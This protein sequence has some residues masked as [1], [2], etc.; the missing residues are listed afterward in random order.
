MP[1]LAPSQTFLT[2]EE[3]DSGLRQKG[4]EINKN[5]KILSTLDSGE[6]IIKNSIRVLKSSSPRIFSQIDRVTD[7]VL[8]HISQ[9]SNSFVSE[10]INGTIFLYPKENPTLC[11]FIE[12]LAHQGGHLI[13]LAATNSS[14][15]YFICEQSSYTKN[16]HTA[17]SNSRNNYV[18]LHSLFTLAMIS[19]CLRDVLHSNLI[20]NEE[21]L[22]ALGRLL[23][24]SRR[25]E[26]DTISILQSNALNRKGL[27]L[28][29]KIS[30]SVKNNI[31]E[32]KFTASKL[33]MKGHDYDF[34]FQTFMEMNKVLFVT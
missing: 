21:K 9:K 31:N 15:D 25:F 5:F 34:S 1:I 22:E 17:E 13:L 10:K 33:N 3:L 28:L 23:Y 12:E 27:Q 32:F 8:I 6:R 7:E 20:N 16:H 4:I 2:D 19:N 18:I 29:K 24:A 26:M 14:L 30:T 11:Y